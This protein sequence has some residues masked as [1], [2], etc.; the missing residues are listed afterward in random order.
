MKNYYNS[1]LN[2]KQKFKNLNGSVS[3]ATK[4]RHKF[5]NK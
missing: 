4:Y 2:I 5:N 1:K 3:N